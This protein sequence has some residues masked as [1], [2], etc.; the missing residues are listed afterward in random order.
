MI[1]ERLNT[2]FQL[3]KLPNGYN[4]LHVHMLRRYHASQLAEAGMSTDHINLLQGRKITGVAHQSYIRIKPETLRNE[5]IEALPYLVIEEVERFRTELEQVTEENKEL[6]KRDEKLNSI[7][8]R[9]A[10]LEKR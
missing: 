10:K 3:G 1:F 2:H 7:L 4:R 8:D 9:L 6:R 5:Y